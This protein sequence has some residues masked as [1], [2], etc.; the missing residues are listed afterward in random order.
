LWVPIP[1]LRHESV[2]YVVSHQQ[3]CQNRD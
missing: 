3:I 1:G 2:L